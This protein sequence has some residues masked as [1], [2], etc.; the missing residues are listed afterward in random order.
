MAF[1]EDQKLDIVRITSI[2]KF[3]LDW[4]L[5]YYAANLSPEAE[6]KVLAEIQSWDDNDLE[7][8]FAKLE[9]NGPNYGI[10]DNPEDLRDA[11]R[12]NICLF[13]GIDPE[14]MSSGSS[15]RLERA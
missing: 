6:A 7:T 9:P 10:R 1:T 13:L 12:L 15:M 4:H 3:D 5:Q 8:D 11:I 2:P 14:L